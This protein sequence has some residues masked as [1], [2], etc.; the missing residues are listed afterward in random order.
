MQK[1][2]TTNTSFGKNTSLSKYLF[3]LDLIVYIM[4]SFEVSDMILTKSRAAFHK[5]H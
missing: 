5:R 4:I 1:Y 2:Q 3:L